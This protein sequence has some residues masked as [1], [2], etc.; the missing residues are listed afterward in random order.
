MSYDFHGQTHSHICAKSLD[1]AF[2]WNYLQEG[3]EVAARSH[4]ENSRVHPVECN[5][6][7]KGQVG[8]LTT[9]VLHTTWSLR[10]SPHDHC[11]PH[12]MATVPPL[13]RNACLRY[14]AGCNCLLCCAAG[15]PFGYHI[16]LCTTWHGC[17]KPEVQLPGSWASPSHPF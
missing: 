12:F 6:R 10:P 15:R 9:T 14:M 17:L 5:G 7:A 16:A 11:A 1:T 13:L 2:P 8:P 3:E 4:E